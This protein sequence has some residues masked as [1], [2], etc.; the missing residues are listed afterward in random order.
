MIEYYDKKLGFNLGSRGGSPFDLIGSANRN[1]VR[2]TTKLMTLRVHKY[3]R[4]NLTTYYVY[5]T[6]SKR[7]KY[8]LNLIVL[9]PSC[10][11][12][13]HGLSKCIECVP[14]RTFETPTIPCLYEP[15]ILSAHVPERLAQGMSLLR[16]R[17]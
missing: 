13:R 11:F 1:F 2:E 12:I 15:F 9:I 14:G 6:T 17:T 10:F 3:R 8:R 7:V 5:Y 4:A 16:K